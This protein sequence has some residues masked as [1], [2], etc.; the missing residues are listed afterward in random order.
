MDR[1]LTDRSTLFSQQPRAFAEGPLALF[2]LR[3][4][5]AAV[6]T[7]GI[8]AAAGA[9]P[10]GLF[11]S[12]ARARSFAT[13][14]DA[15]M[16]AIN[17]LVL[18]TG[19]YDELDRPD[20]RS[21]IAVAGDIGGIGTAGTDVMGT[22]RTTTMATIVTAMGPPSAFTSA[23]ERGSGGGHGWGGGHIGGHGGRHR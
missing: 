11:H 5:L 20:S 18:I 16:R 3:L 21:L 19:R 7:A 1:H 22:R 17:G 15:V 6:R 8:E 10:S 13:S 2:A 23:V 12:E 14:S 9:L 4:G